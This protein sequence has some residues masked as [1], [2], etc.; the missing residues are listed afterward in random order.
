MDRRCQ[1]KRTK[2]ISRHEAPL[3]PENLACSGNDFASSG[4]GNKF[5]GAQVMMQPWSG[6]T[7][8]QA[9]PS[10]RALSDFAQV[11]DHGFLSPANPFVRHIQ[12]SSLRATICCKV[13][14]SN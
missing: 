8:M 9:R 4:Y 2:R 3:Q 5:L 13:S 14:G 11:S 6:T 10:A 12:T 1:R 7:D